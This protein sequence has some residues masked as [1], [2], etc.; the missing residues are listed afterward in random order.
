MAD[1]TQGKAR[2]WTMVLYPESMVENWQE[3]IGDILQLPYAYCIHDKCLDENGDIR[4][5]HVHILVAFSNTTT[6]KN[7]LTLANQLGV[8]NKVERCNNVRHVYNYLIHDTDTCR[9]KNKHL[10]DPSERIVGNNF[11]IGA[12]EQLTTTDKLS[13]KKDLAKLIRKYHFFNF[14]DFDEYVI[15]N[16]D[17]EYYQ[18][19]CENQGYF[20]N[21]V[22]GHYNKIRG[23]ATGE[24][25][26]LNQAID[27]LKKQE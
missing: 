24:Y 5:T 23:I 10:Y 7:V 22:R 11:D 6:Y 9:K 13:I 3:N 27:R 8:A 18:V 25:E 15:D 21:L 1:L 16:L 2:Y 14:D 20:N 19:M 4:K 12:Y 26:M 17:L